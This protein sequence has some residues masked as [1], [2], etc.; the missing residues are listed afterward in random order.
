[1]F[2]ATDKILEIEAK[3]ATILQSIY[4]TEVGVPVDLEKLLK[5]NGLTLKAGNFDDNSIA[6]AYDRSSQTIFISE[7]SPYQRNAFTIAHE[8]GHHFLHR[9][10]PNEVFYRLDAD[11]I[12]SPEKDQQEAEANWFAA[13]LLMPRESM[14]MYSS[15]FNKDIDKLAIVFAVSK[16]AM[17]WRLKNLKLV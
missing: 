2:L 7:N 8:L 16:T 11:L 5:T 17:F 14:I 15:M 1:M 9:D 10:L 12:N 6:G 4:P 3:S 13:S